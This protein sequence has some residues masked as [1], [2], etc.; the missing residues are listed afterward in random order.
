[1]REKKSKTLR[2]HL[3]KRSMERFGMILSREFTKQLVRDI[4]ANKLPFLWRTSHNRTAWKAVIN[5]QEV[6]VVYDKM[7]KMIVTT[8][9]YKEDDPCTSKAES[10]DC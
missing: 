2:R 9:P 8:W 10:L 4:Q 5:D 7:R 1:M 6:V 3:D